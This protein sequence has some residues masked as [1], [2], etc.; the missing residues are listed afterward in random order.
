MLQE[1]F[2]TSLQ[3][4]LIKE[5]IQ[6]TPLPNVRTVRDGDVIVEGLTYIYKSYPIVCTKTGTIKNYSNKLSNIVLEDGQ[7]YAE[8]KNIDIQ[9]SDSQSDSNIA[10]KN[11]LYKQADVSIVDYNYKIGRHFAN[12]TKMHV[13][14]NSYY[15]QQT[16]ELFGEYLRS[17]RDV[18][19]INLMHLYNCFSYRLTDDLYFKYNKINQEYEVCYDE[20]TSLKVILVPVKFNKTYTI[21]VDCQQPMI[22]RPALYNHF[23]LISSVEEKYSNKFE[24]QTKNLCRFNNPFTI[25]ISSEE[26]D[27]L[28]YEKFLY[29]I[30]Q[31]PKANNSSIVVLEG[32]YSQCDCRKVSSLDLSVAHDVD[33]TLQTKPSLLL[34]ND[35]HFYAYNDKIIE[36]LLGNAIH[37]DEVIP[38]NIEYI[39]KRLYSRFD[40]VDKNRN[41]NV[42]DMWENNLREIIFNKLTNKKYDIEPLMQGNKKIGYT[43]KT[44]YND[45]LYDCNGFVDHDA[46]VLLHRGKI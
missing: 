41:F 1:F 15:D 16:H 3:N 27:L 26:K 12:L 19:D 17:L 28:Q 8:F 33:E 10:D 5:I 32:D 38:K 11:A 36:Y 40:E 35:N 34:A 20:D 7:Q 9:Q 39:Q 23:G 45:A 42:N 46:E 29:I 44:K 24:I 31:L 43:Y 22:V 2:T 37:V 13:C 18:Y 21:A 4:S 25:C 30:L 6:S 14:K